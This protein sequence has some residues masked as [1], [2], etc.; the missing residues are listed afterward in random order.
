VD[1]G[2][3]HGVSP[4]GRRGRNGADPYNMLSRPIAARG[5]MR[6]K[7]QLLQAR[8]AHVAILP[9]DAAVPPA[10]PVG[11]SRNCATSWSPNCPR[12]NTS[13]PFVQT[14]HSGLTPSLSKRVRTLSSWSLLKFVMPLADFQKLLKIP[15]QIVVGDYIPTTP[16]SNTNLD[17]WRV[18]Q[19]NY[20]LFVD[21]VTRHG[22]DIEL[23][24]LPDIGV[25]GNSHFPNVRPEQQGDRGSPDGVPQ[26][27][28]SRSTP[29]R[30]V[31]Q[32]GQVTLSL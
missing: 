17:R 30:R 1:A 29:Q 9:V 8:R 25:F 31:R 22:G 13:V 5:C 2:P 26:E 15:I 23:L 14:G 3:K 11:F 6:M 19:G 27:E 4:V 10:D 16:T 7:P 24:N 32:Q 18:L 20:E 12:S 28:E 21:A